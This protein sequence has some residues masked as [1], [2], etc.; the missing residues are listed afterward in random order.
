MNK[1][2][3][4]T[5]T[6]RLI[7]QRQLLG[8]MGIDCWV[9]RNTVTTRIKQSNIEQNHLEQNHLEQSILEKSTLKKSITLDHTNNFQP[10]EVSNQLSQAVPS[11]NTP[12]RNA[13]PAN[14]T[15]QPVPST[16][17]E[18]SNS[19]I[20]RHDN[21]DNPNN[22]FSNSDNNIDNSDT[23]NPPKNIDKLNNIDHLVSPNPIDNNE[24]IRPFHIQ[25]I[26][27]AH[28]VLLADVEALNQNE[29]SYK[30]WHNICQAVNGKV[31]NLAFPLITDHS[32]NRNLL[33]ST[34]PMDTVQLAN[35]SLAG[36]IFRVANSEQ[37]KI[38]KLTT[39][40]KGLYDKRMI[41]LPTL[42]QMT[43]NP[44]LKRQLWQALN[45]LN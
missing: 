18:V 20:N 25:A 44:L 7:S 17:I 21:L 6:S 24:K 42:D 27:Y 28:W 29:A 33:V 16:D 40:A 15:I 10:I 22:N 38:A 12:T 35:A 11:E 13:L 1:K 23:I 37:V 8:Q 4:S 5:S 14:I 43:S 26:H 2:T 34:E 41:Q 32:F 9:A 39:L 31:D 3:I 30:L 19:I 36:F 45:Q